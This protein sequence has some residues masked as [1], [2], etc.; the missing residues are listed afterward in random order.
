M[1]VGIKAYKSNAS[2]IKQ[3]KEMS[4]YH[5]G[6]TVSDL[7]IGFLFFECSN[8]VLLRILRDSGFANGDRKT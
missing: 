8:K 4:T 1:A 6:N 3:F 7:G 2:K 5:R